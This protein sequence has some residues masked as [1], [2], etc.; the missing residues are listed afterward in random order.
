MISTIAARLEK[1]GEPDS[2][3]I[4]YLGALTALC[5]KDRSLTYD[6]VKCLFPSIRGM[7]LCNEGGLRRAACRFLADLLEANEPMVD[8]FME[9]EKTMI[10]E[11][12][13]IFKSE[14]TAAFLPAMSLLGN[15]TTMSLDKIDKLVE[16]GILPALVKALYIP[17]PQT[18][19][20]HQEL[21]KLFDESCSD[22]SISGMDEEY[23]T[24]RESIEK[25]ASGVEL[26][27]RAKMPE[28][29]EERDRSQSESERDQRKLRKEAAWI[30]SNLSAVV[31][32]KMFEED[33]LLEMIVRNAFDP[34]SFQSQRE[35]IFALANMFF[36][37]PGGLDT[38]SRFKNIE[39]LID[40][41]VIAAFVSYIDLVR[42]DH[43]RRQDTASYAESVLF[44]YE[45]LHL[46]L[47]GDS[48]VNFAL[49]PT[50][51]NRVVTQLLFRSVDTL[52]IL[53]RF[54]KDVVQL[55]SLAHG[56]TGPFGRSVARSAIR[57]QTY[58][59]GIVDVLSPKIKTNPCCEKL[60]EKYEGTIAVL[61]KE[62]EELE[63]RVAELSKQL[64][65]KD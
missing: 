41:G 60:K 11:V 9:L 64:E 12:L 50:T 33:N 16:W 52:S 13:H 25:S 39:K 29:N 4:P 27:K 42:R 56:V 48:T 32:Q 3:W 23:T 37:P 17:V 19:I 24:F 58:M 55:H 45:A 21:G 65:E 53:D 2:L 59:Q 14:D 31:P 46:L 51:L 44:I 7:L 63:K 10:S 8:A 26:V 43:K 5:N 47:T 40:V 34:K 61:Q 22:S 35:S 54:M 1:R 6:E 49:P 18:M 15:F 28:W 36:D 30:A 38:D 57:F 20:A 62:K